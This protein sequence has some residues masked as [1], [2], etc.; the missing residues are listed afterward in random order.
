MDK[1]IMDK[2]SKIHM[3]LSGGLAAMSIAALY[4]RWN[5]LL[6]GVVVILVNVYLV[7]LLYE[8]LHRSGFE[9]KVKDGVLLAKPVYLFS[10]PSKTWIGVL[11]VFVVS[12]T[13][14]GFA[15]MYLFS[16][17]IVY[18]GPVVEMINSAAEHHITIP[19]PSIMDSRI[20]ALYFSLVTMITLGYGDYLPVSAAARML[21]MWQIATG[22]L[23]VIGIFPLIISRAAEF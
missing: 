3:L 2:A 18:V 20:E 7:A 1:T 10:F 13:V 16:A 4:F 5:G 22:G 11:A 17:D 21:V 19:P 14:S 23:L 9:R 12:A 15:N 6:S 8:V